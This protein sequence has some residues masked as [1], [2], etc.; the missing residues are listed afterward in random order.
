M[1][2]LKFKTAILIFIGLF[3]F[4]IF[5]SLVWVFY[6]KLR[7]KVFPG[8][9]QFIELGIKTDNDNMVDNDTGNVIDNNHR[10]NDSITDNQLTIND[11]I[12]IDYRVSSVMDN[13]SDKSELMDNVSDKSELK[14]NSNDNEINKSM[15]ESLSINNDPLAKTLS[16]IESK[17]MKIT[18]MSPVFKNY[19]QKSKKSFLGFETQM[20]NAS[21]D[22]DDKNVSI[23]GLST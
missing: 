22:K 4:G 8:K 6:F 21:K 7:K 20:V 17:Y 9:N 12:E 19:L 10:Y 11:K 1:Y 13:V 14:M 15:L 3:L 5:I 18:G 16:N 2:S 23:L